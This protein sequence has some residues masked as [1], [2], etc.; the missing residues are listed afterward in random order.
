MK[1]G[2]IN[3]HFAPF[4]Y[5]RGAK[6][7]SHAILNDERKY[8][9]SFHYIEKSLDTGP[10]INV[11]W[12]NL[13]QN[14]M[15]EQITRELES[16]ALKFFK[17]YAEKMLREKLLA[18]SQSELIKKGGIKPKYYTKKSL[19]RLYEIPD[20]FSFEEICKRKST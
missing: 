16:F 15:V 1:N 4:P 12:Y 2:I 5:Y 11:K 19:D 18:V 8:G 20:F 17:R 6:T 10:I 13:S 7:L 14:K 9:L 3:L